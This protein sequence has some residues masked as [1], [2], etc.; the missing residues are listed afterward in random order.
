LKIIGSSGYGRVNI[1]E[2][3]LR[4]GGDEFIPKPYVTIEL[5]KTVKRMVS[6][7]GSADQKP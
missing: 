5:I 6:E 4:A 3:V 1:R 2:E 7:S